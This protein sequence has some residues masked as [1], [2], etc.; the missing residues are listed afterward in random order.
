MFGGPE[1][2]VLMV[3]TR[4]AAVVPGRTAEVDPLGGCVLAV[5]VRGVTEVRVAV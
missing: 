2:D 1:L 3:P 4:G 5:R